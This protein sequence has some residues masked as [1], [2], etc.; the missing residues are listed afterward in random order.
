M[1]FRIYVT[2]ALVYILYLLTVHISDLKYLTT[3]TIVSQALY[4]A[5]EHH[6]NIKI[7][8]F[9]QN[10]TFTLSI[11]LIVYW[12]LKYYFQWDTPTTQSYWIHDLMIHGINILLVVG[13]VITKPRLE[14]RLAYIPMLAGALYLI[15]A[16]IY[17]AHGHTIY[18]TNFFKTDYRLIY[19][20]IAV[21]VGAPAIHCTG[22]WLT[23]Q[24]DRLD[25]YSILPTAKKGWWQ[26][27]LLQ[28]ND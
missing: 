9:F 10:L 23:K 20:A 4:F 6:W 18:P 8:N 27:K 17:T 11:F 25:K 15:F 16:I 7:P 14:Y 22:V 5:S 24:K 2:I 21:L 12:P 1:L 3:W 28:T 19:D 13:A 26:K